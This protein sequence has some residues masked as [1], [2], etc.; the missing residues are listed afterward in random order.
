MP[1]LALW[2]LS[3]QKR[4]SGGRSGRRP[5]SP[6]P[7]Q[8]GLLTGPPS[9]PPDVST[10]CQSMPILNTCQ[11]ALVQISLWP[12]RACT[13]SQTRTGSPGSNTSRLFVSLRQTKTSNSGRFAPAGN[14][15]HGTVG[16]GGVQLW[17]LRCRAR[18]LQRRQRV[19]ALRAPTLRVEP[20]PPPS[21]PRRAHPVHVQPTLA[22]ACPLLRP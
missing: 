2:I 19:A 9:S 6:Y 13:T 22:A 4:S 15:F 16:T 8:V 14:S 7:C 18:V 10:A 20:R 5:P 1:L 17:R 3:R 21:R 11:S 12:I